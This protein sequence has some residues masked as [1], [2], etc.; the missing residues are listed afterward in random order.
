MGENKNQNINTLSDEELLRAYQQSG[1]HQYISQLYMR[2]VEL[3]YGVCL[4]YYKNRADAKDAT[5][6]IYIL[7]LRRIQGK[8]IDNWKPW[9]YTVT[10]NYC[11]EQLRSRSSKM[12]KQLVADRVYSDEIFHPN[13]ESNEAEL[14]QLE[15]CIEKLE[16]EQKDCI[17]LFYV[18]RKSYQ[19]VVNILGI[20]W[21][22]VRSR[23]Q[24]GRRNLKNCMNK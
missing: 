9:L 1:D 8:S 19:D 17:R 2:Y 6:E 15:S 14:V 24:N 7:L 16:Q 23:I 3:I 10:K 22:Q 5:S 18:E 13:T 20:S 12:P 11:L 21:S 4:K